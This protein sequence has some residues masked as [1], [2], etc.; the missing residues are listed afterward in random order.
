M[1][2]GLFFAKS[3]FW[4][5]NVFALSEFND[6]IFI[7]SKKEIIGRC[8]VCGQEKK[9]SY[10]HI[11]PRAAGGGEKVK[12][13][14]ATDVLEADKKGVDNP[15]GKIYQMGYGGYTLCKECNEYCGRYY[16]KDFTKFYRTLWRS[17]SEFVAKAYSDEDPEETRK[18]LLS[19]SYKVT[20]LNMKPL[21]IAKRVLASFCSIENEAFLVDQIPEIR[22]SIMDKEYRPQCCDFRLYFCLHLGSPAYYATI[23]ALGKNGEVYAFSGMETNPIAFYLTQ[24]GAKMPPVCVVDITHWLTDFDYNASKDLLCVVPFNEALGFRFPPKLIDKLK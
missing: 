3:G 1:L 7:M 11:L 17:V 13:Y 10:E 8:R 23:T 15:Y 19:G 24:K 14:Q 2:K 16:D 22:K 18:I 9:L 20:L 21:N 4:Q 6:I 5:A 12:L